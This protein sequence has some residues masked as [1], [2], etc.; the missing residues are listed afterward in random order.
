MNIDRI[1]SLVPIQEFLPKRVQRQ[2]PNSQK[3]ECY[4]WNPLKR[5]ILH[6]GNQRSP[7]QE[8]F[9]RH[10]VHQTPWRPDPES[11][12]DG[13]IQAGEKPKSA[14]DPQKSGHGEGHEGATHDQNEY[15]E[16][17]FEDPKT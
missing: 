7:P 16:E 17:K 6:L 4:F 1:E 15:E 8:L 2:R 5:V 9:V 12:G 13:I 3:H 14:F 11:E 10:L